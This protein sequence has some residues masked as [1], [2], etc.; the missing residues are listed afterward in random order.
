M[1]FIFEYNIV[2]VTFMNT[3]HLNNFCSQ[4]KSEIKANLFKH[5]NCSSI[6]FHVFHTRFIKYVKIVLT[7]L[8]SQEC[9]IATPKIN[10]LCILCYYYYIARIHYTHKWHKWM[11]VM[12]MDDALV[13]LFA[14]FNKAIYVHD[15]TI[16]N[17]SFISIRLRLTKALEKL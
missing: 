8:F 7:S 9:K 6:F 13:P 16:S 15:F 11:I 12:E 10:L 3:T 4:R 1:K 17:S 2:C 14:G 5:Q